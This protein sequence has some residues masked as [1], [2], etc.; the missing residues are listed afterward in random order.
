MRNLLITALILILVTGN[1]SA[2][3]ETAETRAA[4]AEPAAPFFTWDLLWSG[5]YEYEK[6]LI[7][8]GDLRLH[9]P[10]PGLTLRTEIIDK[11]P[12]DLALSEFNLRGFG[13]EPGAGGAAS[14]SGGL[15]SLSGGLY[16]DLTGSRLL[17]GVLDERGLPARISNPWLRSL[18]YAENHKPST[19]DLKKEPSSTKEAETLLYLWSPQ[20]EFFKNTEALHTRF[21]TFASAK[22]DREGDGSYGGGFDAQFNEKQSLL[23]EGYYS[24]GEIQPRKSTTWFSRAPPLPAREFRLYGF[25]LLYE[26]PYAAL[27]SD[28]A[29][30]ETWAFGRDLYGN[31]GIRIGNF[32]PVFGGPWQL[33]LAA[34]GAGSR[35]T[36]GNGYSPGAAFRSGGKFEWYGKRKSLARASLSLRAPRMG[37]A[38]N[39]SS[40]TLYYRFPSPK[41]V[42]KKSGGNSGPDRSRRSVPANFAISL[43]RISFTADRDARDTAKIT[44]SIS[45]KLGLSIR[46]GGFSPIGITLSGSAQGIRDGGNS[47]PSPFPELTVHTFDTAKVAGE[48]SWSPPGKST[49][50]PG[51]FQFKTRVGCTMK[52]RKDPL[53]DTS[54][55]A[56]ARFK[57]GRFSVKISGAET[58]DKRLFSD[59]SAWDYTVSWRLEKK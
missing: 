3:P 28:W 31:L 8:R 30:S 43:T 24:G 52:T 29:C 11:R 17:H 22:F 2:E 19:A 36:D 10:L 57:Y 32:A 59:P 35:Y 47:A 37:E 41:I 38:F 13:A 14:L 12:A 15:T 49:G 42:R 6:N 48:I 4:E 54:F 56:A 44:D 46:L 9:L 7:N 1:T 26:S 45:G 58:A 20:M 18:P 23:V 5:S 25:G 21:R 27:S 55:S 39:R 34:D 40:S 16:H 51:T 33:S 53:W 50:F